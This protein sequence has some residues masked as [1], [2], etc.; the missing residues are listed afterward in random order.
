MF[1]T[2]LRYDPWFRGLRW[3]LPA[4]IALAYYFVS[5]GRFS[6]YDSGLAKLEIWTLVWLGASFV[7]LPVGYDLRRLWWTEHDL[8]LPVSGR[9][10]AATRL[11]AVLLCGWAPFLFPA[12]AVA[13]FASGEAGVAESLAGVFAGGAVVC[14]WLVGMLA[15]SGRTAG[16]ARFPRWPMLA[17][18]LALA[19]ALQFVSAAPLAIGAAAVALGVAATWLWGMPTAPVLSIAAQREARRDGA[20]RS[21][22]QVLHRWLLRRVLG[23]GQAIVALG[24]VGVG[25]TTVAVLFDP[26]S[27]KLL[28]C[29]AFAAQAL[30]FHQASLQ[31]LRY[32]DALPISRDRLLPYFFLPIP[33]VLAAGSVIVAIAP[34][35]YLDLRR[36][37]DVYSQA[38]HVPPEAWR[39]ARAGDTPVVELA[40]GAVVRPRVYTVVPGIGTYNPYDVP[41]D[42]PVPVWAHQISRALRDVHQLEIAP[43]L[44]EREHLQVGS[45]S[46]Y[47]HLDIAASGGAAHGPPGTRASAILWLWLAWFAAVVTDPRP[48]VPPASRREWWTGLPLRWGKLSPSI[49]L[50][51]AVFW[52]IGIGWVHGYDVSRAVG[53]RAWAWLDAVLP[54]TA[55][56]AITLIVALVA[57]AGLYSRWK[58]RRIEV[59]ARPSPGWGRPLYDEHPTT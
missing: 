48:L 47:L 49:L 32:T 43:E 17:S 12:A 53:A 52:V 44:L 22:S 16:P 31:T 56:G 21:G 37:V 57:L 28:L 51:A 7:L 19:C 42:A 4:S 10:R 26:D 27:T 35:E 30:G 23:N 14:L 38:L 8:S 34:F 59:P 9:S 40:N 11:A 45:T 6:Q 20:S 29:A 54:Q 1:F 3:I 39:F 55:A 33:V 58:L 24:T 15:A 2:L 46:V 18:A 13:L 41:E 36:N 25:A 5:V 50:A